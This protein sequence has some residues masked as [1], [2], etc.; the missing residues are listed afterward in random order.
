MGVEVRI[1]PHAVSV[2][3]SGW[4]RAM[5]WRRSVAVEPSAVSEARVEQRSALECL[6]DHRA[7]GC[8]THNGGKRP[9]RR[10]V[11]TMLGRDVAGKQFWAV[12]AGEESARLL[13]L[14]MREGDFKRFV[15]AVDDPEAAAAT[16]SRLSETA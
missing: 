16:I 11:G 15:L 8:G 4:D 10:R 7:S 13:V 5:N 1:S 14:E 6:I 2:T 12:P 3:L 9:N